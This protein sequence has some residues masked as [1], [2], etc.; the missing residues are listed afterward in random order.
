MK[1]TKGNY[2]R[3]ELDGGFRTVFADDML[4]A[5]VTATGR[6]AKR[7]TRISS[8]EFKETACNPGHQGVYRVH[9]NAG[10]QF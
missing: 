7:F 6:P 1:T 2:Y 4:G 10:Y 5:V 8:N 3:V 9:T